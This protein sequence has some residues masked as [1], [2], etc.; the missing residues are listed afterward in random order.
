MVVEQVHEVVL[1]STRGRKGRRVFHRTG[2]YVEGAVG[3][4]H[5]TFCGMA[6]YWADE[7]VKEEH[8]RKEG[9]EPCISRCFPI[10]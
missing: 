4:D 8:A 5:Q 9:Y 1:G 6:W 3:K 7:V 2:R 10:D